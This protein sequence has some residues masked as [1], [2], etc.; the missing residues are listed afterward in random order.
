M[1]CIYPTA[2]LTV[3][4]RIRE[5]KE[6]LLSDSSLSSVFAV[7]KYG[8]PIQRAFKIEKEYAIMLQPEL[9]NTRSQELEACYHDAGQ[10]YW[11]RTERFLDSQT[12]IMPNSKVIVL[13]YNEAQDIDNEEDWK[14][15][16]LKMH[17][18]QGTQ[19]TK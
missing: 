16:E 10:W 11:L 4:G 17:L 12:S 8:H 7:L 19:R 9:A 18:Q 14:L 3:P 1:C 13:N 15:A 6:L 2:V 5:G